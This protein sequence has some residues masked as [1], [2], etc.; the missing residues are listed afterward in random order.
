MDIV[1]ARKFDL[2]MFGLWAI[3]YV[4]IISLAFLVPIGFCLFYIVISIR[5]YTIGEKENSAFKK[6]GAQKALAISVVALM[7]V[8]LIWW[9]L[10]SWVF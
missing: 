3:I 10:L 1:E 9:L 8:I 7:L 5:Q 2:Y 4:V 6:R